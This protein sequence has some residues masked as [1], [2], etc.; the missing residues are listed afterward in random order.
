MIYSSI[1][2]LKPPQPNGEKPVNPE[3]ILALL[4]QIN[5]GDTE[6]SVDPNILDQLQKIATKFKCGKINGQQALQEAIILFFPD[7]P[8]EPDK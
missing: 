7:K 6:I 8:D 1:D 2:L 5:A 4:E 3:K